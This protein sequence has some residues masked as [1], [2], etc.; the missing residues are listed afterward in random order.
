VAARGADLFVGARLA[1]VAPGRGWTVP[2]DR[3]AELDVT[4]GAAAAMFAPN[5]ATWGNDPALGGLL[6]PGEGAAL[7][8]RLRAR[9]ADDATGVIR[10]HLRQI[11]REAPG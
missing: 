3:P 9:T 11:V 8:Q 10:W 6:G 7:E 1:R 2:V 4:A 5:L